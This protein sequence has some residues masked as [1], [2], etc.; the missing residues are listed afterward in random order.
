MCFS[1]SY[2]LSKCGM[3]VCRLAEPTEVKTRCTTAALAGVAKTV[4]AHFATHRKTSTPASCCN[5][6]DYGSK[7]TFGVLIGRHSS[8][9]VDPFSSLH[10]QCVAS[11]L[12]GWSSLHAPPIPLGFL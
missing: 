1:T 4:T 11:I 6:R 8:I 3:P 12:S 10:H 7:P 2:L 5:S 9:L